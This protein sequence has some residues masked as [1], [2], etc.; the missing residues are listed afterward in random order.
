MNSEYQLG[1]FLT[2]SLM[3]HVTNWW[4]TSCIVSLLLNYWMEMETW[5]HWVGTMHGFDHFIAIRKGEGGYPPD[6]VLLFKNSN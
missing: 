2:T 4:Y 3:Q 5:W 6:M 1:D